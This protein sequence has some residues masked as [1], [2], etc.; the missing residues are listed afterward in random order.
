MTSTTSA[1]ASLLSSIAPRTDCSATRSWGG[2]RSMLG[3]LDG[4]PSKLIPGRNS[5]T[6]TRLLDRTGCWTN[7]IYVMAP[8]L[9]VGTPSRVLAPASTQP[10]EGAVDNP[11]CSARNDVQSLWTEV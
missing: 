10:V 7:Y 2:V 1:M 9:G 6:L 4:G 3:P 11:V 8:T 5:A